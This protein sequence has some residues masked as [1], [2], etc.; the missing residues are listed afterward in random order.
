MITIILYIKVIKFSLFLCKSV[1]REKK[2][3]L[4]EYGIIHTSKP[5]LKKS[6]W[7]NILKRETEKE[8]TRKTN[9]SCDDSDRGKEAG[10]AGLGEF[11]STTSQLH[12]I[13]VEYF[14]RRPSSDENEKDGIVQPAPLLLLHPPPAPRFPPPTHLRADY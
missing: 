8:E 11:S 6:K 3:W 9:S 1:I 10:R 4:I 13:R 14:I 12:R 7:K 2:C 5:H